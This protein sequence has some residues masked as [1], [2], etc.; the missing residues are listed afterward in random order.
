MTNTEKE[1][2]VHNLASR[3]AIYVPFDG[4]SMRIVCTFYGDDL[5]GDEEPYFLAE[6]EESGDNITMLYTDVDLDYDMFYELQLL[7]VAD[8]QQLK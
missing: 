2:L 6:G 3:A 8:L 1:S 7:R 5:D 4:E